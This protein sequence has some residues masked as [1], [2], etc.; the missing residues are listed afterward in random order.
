MLRNNNTIQQEQSSNTVVNYIGVKLYL[1]SLIFAL[2]SI[3]NQSLPL[4]TAEHFEIVLD[5]PSTSLIYLTS[6][7]FITY[8]IMQIPGG[9]VLD[10]IGSRVVLPTGILISL[11]GFVM[12]WF[13]K[14]PTFIVAGRLISGFGCSI[15]YICG[16]FV[17]TRFFAHKNLALL[18]G[19]LE[20]VSTLGSILAASPL[21]HAIEKMGWT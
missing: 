8:S 9:L 14:S 20:A 15:A 17:A 18:I 5:I 3:F 21:L 7:F 19:V 4:S 2:I 6:A 12:F 13:A 10:T 16:I 11:I 1:I